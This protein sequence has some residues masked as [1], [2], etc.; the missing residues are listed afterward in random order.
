LIN[1]K[2]TYAAAKESLVNLNTS[3]EFSRTR[4]ESGT[5]DFVTYLQSLN[6]KNSADFQLVQAKY[7]IMLRKLILDIF[8]GELSP[9]N[10]N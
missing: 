1:A 5:I 10:T 7:G 4:Y 8:T 3:F 9:S 2:T 6:N